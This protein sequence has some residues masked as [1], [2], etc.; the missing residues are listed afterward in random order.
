MK[1]ENERFFWIEKESLVALDEHREGGLPRA[2]I[3]I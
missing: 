3:T 2:A 1:D